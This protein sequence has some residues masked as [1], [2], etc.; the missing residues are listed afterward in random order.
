MSTYRRSRFSSLG[1]TVMLM[2]LGIGVVPAA[3]ADDG[4]RKTQAAAA[5]PDDWFYQT[6]GN[7]RDASLKALEGKPA[8]DLTI[9]RWI[10][11]A[12]SIKD[13]QGKVVVVDFWATWCGPCMRAI[14]KNVEMVDKYKKQGLVFIGVHDA[15][16]GWDQAPEVVKRT[17]I[18]YSVGLDAKDGTSAK[19]FSLKFFPTY[20]AIDKRGI[21]RAVGLLPNRVEDVVK[22]LLAEPGPSA[23]EMDREFGP[24]FYLGGFRRPQAL[25]DIEGRELSSIQ[26]LAGR[27]S[28]REGEGDWLG[29]PVS[30]SDRKSKAMVLAFLAPNA[31][32]MKEA[33]ALEKLREE[34]AKDGVVLMGVC[35]ARSNWDQMKKEHEAKKIGFPVLRDVAA[36][37][38]RKTAPGGKAHGAIARDLGVSM[39]PATFVIDAEGKVRAAGVRT[40]KVTAVVAKVL[41]KAPPEKDEKDRKSDKGGP[42]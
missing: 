37:D 5:F 41:G 35:D 16:S 34:L 29:T 28:G 24:E 10:G 25:Q 19:A 39:F 14:P 3:L 17:K 23:K 38:A 21:V 7:Q 8:P 22:A 1:A 30:E 27:L 2:M 42:K 26:G 18:N 13:S 36:D 15:G 31:I 32:A 11:E 33:A 6:Q 40:D 9:E 12:E 4:G 20:I